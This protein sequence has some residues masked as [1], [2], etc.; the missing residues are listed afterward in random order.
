M[1]VGEWILSILVEFRQTMEKSFDKSN[2]D[3]SV[4]QI[5]MDDGACVKFANPLYQIA[6]VTI[7][8]NVTAN[9]T[10]Q[11]MQIKIYT[12]FFSNLLFSTF[13]FLL[14]F[15]L[16]CCFLI[17]LFLFFI[18]VFLRENGFVL[19]FHCCFLPVFAKSQHSNFQ[20]KK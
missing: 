6:D 4:P 10:L 20:T 18:F 9:Q 3:L 5:F 7:V 13:F 15:C 17:F 1:F 19:L 8:F 12:F 11:C 16:L 14:C 2:N